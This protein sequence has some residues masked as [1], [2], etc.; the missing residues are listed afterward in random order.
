MIYGWGMKVSI[1]L[2]TYTSPAYYKGRFVTD[3]W[4]LEHKLQRWTLESISEEL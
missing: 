1:S 4:H 2:A 3:G